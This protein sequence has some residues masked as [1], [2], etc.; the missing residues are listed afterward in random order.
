[1]ASR[2]SEKLRRVRVR[3]CARVRACPQ[4]RPSRARA[5]SRR[6]LTAGA[7]PSARERDATALAAASPARERAC[8]SGARR[9]SL[10]LSL[11]QPADPETLAGAR[12]EHRRPRI[13]PRAAVC[14]TSSAEPVHGGH[15]AGIGGPVTSSARSPRAFKSASRPLVRS[16]LQS[17]ACDPRPACPRARAPS[18]GVA[19]VSAR[20]A[21]SVHRGRRREAAGST[22]ART[23]VVC[24]ALA[25][26][27]RAGAARVVAR[28]AHRT[29]RTTPP[30]RA[31]RGSTGVTGAA[32]ASRQHSGLR[33]RCLG[34]RSRSHR[35]PEGV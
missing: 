22:A 34:F 28:A 5:L 4:A 30:H 9:S 31:R 19:C 23:G 7:E 20:C 3:S 11:E 12:V 8:A 18:A 2:E 10:P 35:Q 14:E 27:L 29:V 17:G 24:I 6:R 15:A 33:P 26:P 25:A 13:R 32:S 16:R 1:M 21:P